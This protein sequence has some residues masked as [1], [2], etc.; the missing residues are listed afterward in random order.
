MVVMLGSTFALWQEAGPRF[1]CADLLW[2]GQDSWERASW[3]A[4]A[5]SGTQQHH[6]LVPSEHPTLQKWA[7]MALGLG[8]GAQ[9]RQP[10]GEGQWDKGPFLRAFGLPPCPDRALPPP[11]PAGAPAAALCRSPV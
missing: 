3:P 10:G 4:K 1:A 2:E 6:G 8:W 5:W 11:G 9:T 7:W